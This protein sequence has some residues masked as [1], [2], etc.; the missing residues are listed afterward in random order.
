MLDRT[1]EMNTEVEV[2]LTAES[3][4]EALRRVR[5]AMCRE[6]TRYYL[7]GVYMHHVARVGA[8]RFVA[9]D[10]HHLATADIGAAASQVL[11]QGSTCRHCVTRCLNGATHWFCN[12]NRPCRAV[13]VTRDLNSATCCSDWL[14][15]PH[16]RNAV[17]R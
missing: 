17:T 16:G 15:R 5:H 13:A 11:A 6:E 10:G 4:H 3:L 14:N 9:T 2:E 7:D 8:L 1:T 12:R